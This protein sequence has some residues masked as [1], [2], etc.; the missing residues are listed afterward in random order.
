MKLYH[1]F[2]LFKVENNRKKESVA[3]Q[4]AITTININ[5][6]KH[7]FKRITLWIK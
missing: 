1:N 6:L 2:F 7:F 4:K 3:T 5:K